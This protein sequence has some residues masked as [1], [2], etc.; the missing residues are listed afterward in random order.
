MSISPAAVAAAIRLLE[1]AIKTRTLYVFQRCRIAGNQRFL[2]GATPWFQLTLSFQSGAERFA[3]FG[4]H[5]RDGKTRSRVLGAFTR[6]VNIDPGLGVAGIS[7]VQRPICT[8][9]HV[10]EEHKMIVDPDAARGMPAA[11]GFPVAISSHVAFT[12]VV[13]NQPEFWRRERS[14]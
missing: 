5:Q 8:T 2:F 9:D 6:I 11:A 13:R 10:H 12:Q 7:R 4:V 14:H 1:T 3:L